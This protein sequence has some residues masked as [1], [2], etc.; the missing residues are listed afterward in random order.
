MNP[1][2]IYDYSTLINKKC[3]KKVYMIV[4]MLVSLGLVQ[5]SVFVW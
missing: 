3:K 5:M 4:R 1:N 2:I